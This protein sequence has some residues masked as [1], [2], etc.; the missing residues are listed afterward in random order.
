MAWEIH[1]PDEFRLRYGA[2]AA[3]S[4]A[5]GL[6]SLLEGN[7]LG[8]PPFPGM[9]W[10]EE[11]LPGGEAVVVGI[12]DSGDGPLAYLL[13]ADRVELDRTEEVVVERHTPGGAEAVTLHW[14]TPRR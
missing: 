9:V 4:F 11:R 2:G 6:K 7:G 13:P 8:I 5:E 14:F 12:A 1:Q 3:T 10:A